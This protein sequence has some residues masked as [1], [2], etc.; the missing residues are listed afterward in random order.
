MC[1]SYS[2]AI[3]SLISICFALWQYKL[4]ADITVS[5]A[6]ILLCKHAEWNFYH[7]AYHYSSKGDRGGLPPSDIVQV[8][9]V[10][11]GAAGAPVIVM[12]KGCHCTWAPMSPMTSANLT[13]PCRLSA[14]QPSTVIVLPV[15]VAP[16]SSSASVGALAALYDFFHALGMQVLR[17]PPHTQCAGTLRLL[18]H[19]TLQSSS[20]V[21]RNNAH[22][23][24]YDSPVPCHSRGS[25][26][27][28][29]DLACVV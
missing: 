9:F 25:Q 10:A 17:S 2:S 28:H 21:L 15:I 6:H 14:P 3:Q 24:Q 13:S 29:P 1:R 22:S 19:G 26:P 23:M 7:R 16:V 18:R 11:R 8:V 12:E 20:T 27:R 4:H 5:W